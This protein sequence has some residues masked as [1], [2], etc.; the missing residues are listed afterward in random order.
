MR[1]EISELHERLKTTMIYVTHDQV[2]AMTMADKIVVLQRRQH[3]AGGQPARS[4]PLPPQPLRRRLH[5]QSED[6]PHR[7]RAGQEARRQ[8]DRH[9]P[10]APARRSESG[11]TLNGKVGVAEHLGSDTFFHV[12]V[13]EMEEP[14]TVRVARRR[15]AQ[16]R[17][18]GASRPRG[19]AHPPLRRQGSAD[20]VTPPRRP[21][22]APKGPSWPPSSTCRIS[23]I[24]RR[25]SAGRATPAPISRRAS[26]ISAS[27]TSTAPTRRSISTGCS[28][29][30]GA[31][32]GDR[33]RRRH[34]GRPQG[35]RR[36]S[37]RRTGSPRWSSSRPRGPMP[38]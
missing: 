9:P 26:S 23:T 30:E 12:H 11:G 16:A 4:L 14:M 29:R 2:E 7:G 6:E 35:P 17:R 36:R 20:R 34:G 28:R 15:A 3:R 1:L 19:G 18:H 25:R 21:P 33:R 31:G 8:D 13:D 24:C 38:A 5:R 37:P 32:L 27:A 22:T 10:R